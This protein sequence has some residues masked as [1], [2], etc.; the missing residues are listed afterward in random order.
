MGALVQ[1][2]TIGILLHLD[3]FGFFS[4]QIFFSFVN[5]VITIFGLVLG[6]MA[7]VATKRL[8]R[9]GIFGKALAGTCI[10]GLLVL[11]F[12]LHFPRLVWAVKM[13][14][15]LERNQAVERAKATL[16]HQMEMKQP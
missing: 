11:L 1:K 7:L 4:A 6:I 15:A 16:R 5:F 2:E 8:G 14:S 9:T 10:N 3:Q 12:L 13:K